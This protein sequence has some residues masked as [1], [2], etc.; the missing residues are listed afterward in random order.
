MKHSVFLVL[1]FLTCMVST[2][3]QQ[4]DLYRIKLKNG[5]IIKAELIRV[6]PDSFALIRQYGMESKINFSEITD[7]SF[8]ETNPAMINRLDR[9]VITKRPLPDSGWIFGYQLGASLGTDE[10]FPIT[11]FVARFTGLKRIGRTT[12]AGFSCGIDP[13]SYYETALGVATIDFREYLK[14]KPKSMFLYANA[15][16][17][18]NLTE[19]NTVKYGGLNFGFGLGRSYRTRHQNI[20]SMMLG[21]K[22]QDI[23]DYY[24]PWNRPGYIKYINARRIEFKVECL[25]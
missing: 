23:K 24:Q 25:F 18:F 10:Y 19:P 6:V 4:T 8:S 22:S 15:G 17:G 11:S 13:Y 1:F 20:F 3:G 2:Y 14:N 16:Y 5:L 9:Q 21:Y 12:Q 7:I